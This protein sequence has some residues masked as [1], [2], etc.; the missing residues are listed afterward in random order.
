MQASQSTLYAIL[1]ESLVDSGRGAFVAQ[2]EAADAFAAAR[3]AESLGY[4]VVAV[5]LAVA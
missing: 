3:A 5:R 1:V 2:I 4:R